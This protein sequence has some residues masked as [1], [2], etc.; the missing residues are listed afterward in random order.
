MKLLK[1]NLIILGAMFLIA[2]IFLVPLL[3]LD[4][5]QYFILMPIL[6]VV[7]FTAV[8]VAVGIVIYKV[9]FSSRKKKAALLAAGEDAEATI[10]AVADT[11]VTLQNGLYFQVQFDLEVQPAAGAAFR[12][13]VKD[14]VSRVSIAQYQPGVKVRVKYNP[15]NPAEVAIT[16][17]AGGQ[18]IVGAGAT[19]TAPV[20]GSDLSSA[21][22]TAAT[23]KTWGMRGIILMIA[24]PMVIGIV[25]MVLPLGAYY[26]K[27]D[28]ASF[29][30]EK[31]VGKYD[32]VTAVYRDNYTPAEA[33]V[34]T[35]KQGSRW[36]L[37]RLTVK[38]SG[39][40]PMDIQSAQLRLITGDGKEYSANI[41]VKT[42]DDF[43][44]DDLAPGQS[45]A[46]NLVFE[47]PLS[48]TPASIKTIWGDQL[49]VTAA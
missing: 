22:A 20:Y 39:D 18:P 2:A 13:S 19:E 7:V 34:F 43:K 35:P 1:L 30:I 17:H 24:I 29:F 8:M 33:S 25:A 4:L 11:G 21:P 37:V 44:A 45:Y 26:K 6:F 9:F 49:P 42:G 28:I 41:V 32:L 27:D 16:G 48:A 10:L 38:N 40:K 36:V 47:I 5:E 12:A 3:F 46:G 14:Y 23:G 15:Q 31:T